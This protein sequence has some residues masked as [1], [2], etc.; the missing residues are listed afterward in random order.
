MRIQPNH[1]ITG[2]I[3]DYNQ[4]SLTF[5]KEENNSSKV[6]AAIVQD[7]QNKNYIS[8][9]TKKETVF[10]NPINF[11]SNKSNFIIE[12][13][14]SKED[15]FLYAFELS[16]DYNLSTLFNAKTKIDI[17]KLKNTILEL[18]EEHFPITKNHI[19]REFKSEYIKPLE[20][21]I[22][23][24]DE[25]IIVYY[26]PGQHLYFDEKDILRISLDKT[27]EYAT[28]SR[29][30]VNPIKETNSVTVKA[31]YSENKNDIYINQHK[32]TNI[33]QNIIRE[34]N[35]E[36]NY[37]KKIIDVPYR[38]DFNFFKNKTRQEI[39][40]EINFLFWVSINDNLEFPF[41]TLDSK[42]PKEIPLEWIKGTEEDFHKTMTAF[43][44]HCIVNYEQEKNDT[45]Y[46]LYPKNIDSQI[47]ERLFI[48]GLNKF[49]D[50]D[51]KIMAKIQDEFIF[52]GTKITVEPPSE[53]QLLKRSLSNISLKKVISKDE[54]S[55]HN[56][57]DAKIHLKEWLKNK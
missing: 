26:L 49:N 38:F 48:Y 52:K 25:T 15:M 27:Q 2:E 37:F 14:D 35:F 29:F 51:H 10:I 32:Q 41:L 39:K 40:K 34:S 30:N 55:V 6:K 5:I 9:I 54:I 28:E 16:K 19:D 8:I 36:F 13:F 3:K 50:K 42:K 11:N 31:V 12:V 24:D 33:L 22:Y 20:N 56:I 47:D 7:N 18:L 53:F 4:N 44:I 45:V 17:L 57:M 1:I 23:I 21:N 46:V 43:M